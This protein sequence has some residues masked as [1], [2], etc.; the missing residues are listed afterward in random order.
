M[1]VMESIGTVFGWFERQDVRTAIIS[2]LIVAVVAAAAIPI[3]GGSVIWGYRQIFSLF[4]SKSRFPKNPKKCLH[5]HVFPVQSWNGEVT[6]RV[7]LFRS[8]GGQSPY[9][10]VI[11][12]YACGT[13]FSSN[14]NM[15]YAVQ[16]RLNQEGFPVRIRMEG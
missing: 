10:E 11:Y 12:C 14:E 4:G 8:V 5:A 2:G 1:G 7:D 9:N 16:L 3:V 15:A 6:H 13:R